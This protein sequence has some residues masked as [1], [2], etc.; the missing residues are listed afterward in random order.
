MTLDKTIQ[1]MKR[2]LSEHISV[3]KRK[4]QKI[5]EI[6]AAAKKQINVVKEEI[7]AD[8]KK[9]RDMERGFMIFSGQSLVE[10]KKV[11]EAPKKETETQ[12]A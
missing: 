1:D 4:Q 6:E 12:I 7:R 10:P 3:I 9:H 8:V 11:E 2:A 5:K